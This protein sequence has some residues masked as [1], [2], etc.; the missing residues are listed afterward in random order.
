MDYLSDLIKIVLPAALVLYA[1]YLVI[2]SFLQK[3]FDRQLIAIKQQN[4]ETIL[5]LRL[6]A[7][8]RMALFL[9]RIAPNNM[10]IRLME[11]SL[12]AT[13]FQQ[14]LLGEIRD[15]Y[16]H[17]HSQQIYMS[18]EAWNV[19]QNAMNQLIGVIQTASEKMGPEDSAVD[20]SSAIFNQMA[21]QQNDFVRSALSFIKNEIR[22]S[23]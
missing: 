23:F 5:P 14:K 16:H 11:P 4:T 13:A 6:Q 15:E 8:E 10:L 2:R 3:D 21:E 18:D 1:M 12:S 22:Q 19:I 20:L 7:Y 17:N 9:E